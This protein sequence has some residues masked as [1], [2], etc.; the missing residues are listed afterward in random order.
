MRPLELA[1]VLPTFNERENLPEMLRRL[2]VVLE[3]L[4]YEV[5]IVDDDSPDGTARSLREVA[6]ADP[7]IRVL[8]RVNRRGLASACIEGMLATAAP[9]FAV[10]DAD[11]QHDETILPSMLSK[12]QAE[13]L[14]LVV[15]TRHAVGGSAEGLSARRLHLSNLGK[16]LSRLIT[17]AEVSDPMS[18]FFVVDRRFFDEVVHTLSGKG[19]KILLDLLASSRREVRVGEVAYQF[20]ARLHGDSKL[21]VLVGL[22]YLQLLIDKLLGNVLPSRFVIFGLVGGTG[23]LLHL[24]V[25]QQLLTRTG[26]SF[27]VGQTIATFVVMTT[28]YLLNNALTWRDRRRKGF[29]A[30]GGLLEFYLAC[31]IGAFLNIEI[32]SSIAEKGIPW[33]LAGFLG[34]LIGSVWNYAVTSTTIW[35][36]QG[37]S[38]PQ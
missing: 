29:A 25:L 8:Q 32:A 26:A 14:D 4:S 35:R 2:A 5:I 22:E 31:S 7:R 1:V 28:N 38:S 20:R 19:F 23:V 12:L 17:H 24:I 6:R 34:L 3:S 37:P 10:L 9:Y 15:G 13:E 36:R 18:G 16:T 30:V 11:L 33:Y 27:F 21:D